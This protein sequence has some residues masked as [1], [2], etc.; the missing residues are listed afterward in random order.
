M[1]TIG[2]LQRTSL[3]DYPDKVACTVFF[4]GCNFRCGFCHNP[5]LVLNFKQSISK[6]EFF[7]FLDSRKKVL[8][9]VVISGGE[10]CMSYE[11][12]DFIDE[13]KKRGLLVKLDTNGSYP[14]ILNK[15][16]DKVDYVAMDIKT[17][18]EEYKKVVGPNVNLENIQKSVKMIM[19]RAKDYEFRTTV[20]K[21]IFSEEVLRKIGEWL[22]GAKRYN[23]QQFDKRNEMIS[24]KYKSERLFSEREFYGFA[25]VAR[26]YFSEVAIRNL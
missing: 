10:P 22:K 2:G 11:I 1:Q 9:G 18:L 25:E 16:I 26:E 21:S 4:N 13:V 7:K 24:D 19:E 20:I 12:V 17:S 3:V 8:D 23:L 15:V 14:E 6:E 5:F